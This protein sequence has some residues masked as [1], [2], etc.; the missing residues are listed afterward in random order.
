MPM[1]A[2][3]SG[4]SC[5]CCGQSKTPL[6][7]DLDGKVPLCNAC[8]IRFKKYSVICRSCM[9]VPNKQ[10]SG[11]PRCGKC[12]T[13]GAYFRRPGASQVAELMQHKIV[14]KILANMEKARKRRRMAD[15]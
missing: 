1:P 8:G 14:L 12:G 13:W 10:D 2:S 9:H 11:L 6:W 5:A 7:R 3:T 15:I 4:K